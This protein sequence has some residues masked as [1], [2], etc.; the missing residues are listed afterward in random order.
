M[1]MDKHESI[2][3]NTRYECLIFVQSFYI[4]RWV[5]VILF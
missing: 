3:E 5:N 4:S 2:L 1:Y